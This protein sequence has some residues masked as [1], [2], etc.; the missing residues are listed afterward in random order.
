MP[1]LAY[2]KMNEEEYSAVGNQS[3]TTPTTINEEDGIIPRATK[4][5][6]PNYG[7]IVLDNDGRAILPFDFL[8][9]VFEQLPDDWFY[10]TYQWFK[11]FDKHQ[12]DLTGRVAAPQELL[13]EVVS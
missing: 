9:A 11:F 12:R 5:V 8:P 7:D 4:I 2:V 13:T 10:A 3:N 6:V 1:P